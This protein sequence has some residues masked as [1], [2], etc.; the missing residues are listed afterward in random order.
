[1]KDFAGNDLKVGD[2]I[3]VASISECGEEIPELIMGV[4]TSIFKGYV[5]YN[6]CDKDDWDY[7]DLDQIVKI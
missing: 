3:A 1:M 4:I 5:K 7:A 2:K 6:Y